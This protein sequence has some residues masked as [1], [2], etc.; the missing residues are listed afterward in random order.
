MFR[1]FLLIGEINI[2]FPIL[3]VNRES[4]IFMENPIFY[5][6]IDKRKPTVEV[7]WVGLPCFIF[8]VISI[9]LIGVLHALLYLNNPQ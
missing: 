1:A 6:L 3:L 5:V 7:G 8:L 9:V 4:D 2:A